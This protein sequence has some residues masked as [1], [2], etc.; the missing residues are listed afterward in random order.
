MNAL[1]LEVF[2]GSTDTQNTIATFKPLQNCEV[3]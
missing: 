1:L 2:M 3:K